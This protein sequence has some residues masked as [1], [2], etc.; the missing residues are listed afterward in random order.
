MAVTYV[1]MD[2]LGLQENTYARTHKSNVFNSEEP[3][4]AYVL[5]YVLR[6]G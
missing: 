3:S 5:V 4:T 6:T 1:S 2:L